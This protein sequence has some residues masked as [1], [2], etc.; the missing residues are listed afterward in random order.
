MTG[1]YKPSIYSADYLYN[2]LLI[3]ITILSVYSCNRF[4]TNRGKKSMANNRKIMRYHSRLHCG[5]CGI[6]DNN[7]VK[8]Y[9][10]AARIRVFYKCVQLPS[11]YI[12]I[13]LGIYRVGINFITLQP[14]WIKPLELF[15]H[16]FQKNNKI[17]NLIIKMKYSN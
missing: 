5:S 17:Q 14:R 3:C 2:Y 9:I 10:V 15:F 13:A 1:A 16:F 7:L 6:F 4:I 8:R 12:P 11:I